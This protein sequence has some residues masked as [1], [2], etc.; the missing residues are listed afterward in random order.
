MKLKFE[1]YLKKTCFIGSRVGLEKK[2]RYVVSQT[3]TAG[4][5]WNQNLKGWQK[6]LR[7]VKKVEGCD[8][9]Q[10]KETIIIIVTNLS[11]L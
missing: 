2:D 3:T 6:I 4:K 1:Y 10:K 9:L 11:R 5:I 8:W 7:C